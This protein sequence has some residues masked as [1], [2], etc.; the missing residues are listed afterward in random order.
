MAWLGDGWMQ[1]PPALAL[2][3]ALELAACRLPAACLAPADKGQK[4]RELLDW[5]TGTD[6]AA[7]HW[8]SGSAWQ[9]SMQQ[10]PVRGVRGTAIQSVGGGDSGGSGG[11]AGGSSKR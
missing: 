4:R 6:P 7:D 10:V 5:P 1:L 3:L 9:V 8:L 11:G 2:P